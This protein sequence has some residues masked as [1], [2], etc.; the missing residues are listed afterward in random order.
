MPYGL[1]INDVELI[2]NVLET[3]NKVSKALLFG[4]RAKGNFEAGSDIDIAIKGAELKLNDVIDL[5]IAFDE[6]LLPYKFDIV[7]YYRISEPD[8]LDHINRVG[9]ELYTT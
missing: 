9:I 1:E 2:K 8:L 5:R 7:I 4:S 3:N 6:L